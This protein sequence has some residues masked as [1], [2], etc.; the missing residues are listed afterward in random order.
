MTTRPPDCKMPQPSYQNPSPPA[1]PRSITVTPSGDPDV[2]SIG[3]RLFPSGTP[4]G[5]HALWI[6][7]FDLCHPLP[8]I[9]EGMKRAA[10]S[11]LR[12]DPYFPRP[13][14]EHLC[15]VEL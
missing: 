8:F 7:D 12:N 3:H 4:F 9:A 10:H 5:H 15:D 1:Q 6:L 14:M 13:Y 11:F 2:L